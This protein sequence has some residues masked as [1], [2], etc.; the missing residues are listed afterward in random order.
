MSI[1]TT[2][3]IM[4]VLALSL[5]IANGNK[6]SML[7]ALEVAE[8]EL[9]ELLSKERKDAYAHALHVH[10]ENIDQLISF[11]EI[12]GFEEASKKARYYAK[13]NNLLTEK[14]NHP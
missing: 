9:N 11:L 6:D 4:S 3:D 2:K 5:V 1:Y 7:H 10:R 14:T 12:D 8:Q 13:E